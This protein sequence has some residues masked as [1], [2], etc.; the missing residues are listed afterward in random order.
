MT[1]A[2]TCYL[3]VLLGFLVPMLGLGVWV[4]RRTEGGEDFLLVGWGLW[5]PLLLGTTLATLIGTGSSLGAVGFA[6]SSGWA[7]LLYGIGGVAGVFGLYVIVWGYLADVV[8]DAVQSVILSW[9][10]PSWQA[11]S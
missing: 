9:A 6:Y 2:N 11:S 10:S 5:T 4:A 7:G 1:E 8:T 3:L